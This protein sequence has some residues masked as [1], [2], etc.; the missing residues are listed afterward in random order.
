LKNSHFESS[1]FSSVVA[2][3]LEHNSCSKYQ[4]NMNKKFDIH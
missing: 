4:N 3:L 1:A 2:L